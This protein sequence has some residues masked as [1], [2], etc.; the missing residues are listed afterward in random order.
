MRMGVVGLLA[1]VCLAQQQE[2]F[3]DHAEKAIRMG[4]IT[5]VPLE[6]A[7]ALVTSQAK[8]A[9]RICVAAAESDLKRGLRDEEKLRAA[10]ARIEEI[11][12]R[13]VQRHPNDEAA[14]EA[15]A[16]GLYFRLRVDAA[17]GEDTET[18]DWLAVAE[19]LESVREYARA[20]ARLRAGREASGVDAGALEEKEKELA[21]R[22]A[23]DV[24]VTEQDTLSA[25]LDAIQALFDARERKEG[26]ARLAAFLE[27]VKNDDTLYNDAV[28][29]AKTE[30]RLGLK[31][32]YKV[33]NVA[34]GRLLTAEVPRGDRWKVERGSGSSFAE[35]RHYDRQGELKR[36]MTV[37]YFE[38]NTWYVLGDTKY[39]GSNV[40]GMALIAERDVLEAVLDVKRRSRLVKKRLNR[41]L[42]LAQYFLIGGYG[43]K[44]FVQFRTWIWKGN[45]RDWLTYRLWS[46][47]YEDVKD[48]DPEAASVIESLREVKYVP[49]KKR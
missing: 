46:I 31:V 45:E 37:R 20:V 32:D 43:R 21:E 19:G 2:Q 38:L 7:V 16:E 33:R 17:T 26:K 5:G 35:L 39:D 27:K 29:V 30:K 9:R 41:K 10:A 8:W 6:R 47:E 11:G 36:K 34:L 22:A 44:D 18:E 23:A 42:G 40:K 49:K 14:T 4:M 15:R 25:E 12:A 13:A 3:I 28:T 24:P 1:A 48:L